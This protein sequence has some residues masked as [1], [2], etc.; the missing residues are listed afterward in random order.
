M[1]KDSETQHMMITGTTGSGKTNCFHHL[2]PQIRTLGQRA[3]I[4]DTTGEFVSRYY[5]EGKDIILNPL[6]ARSESWSPWVECTEDYH[7]EELASNLIPQGVPR[8][9]LVKRCK[10]HYG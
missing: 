7:F 6:D 4:V 1:I 3:L 10:N 5:R 2:L 9:I 8:S